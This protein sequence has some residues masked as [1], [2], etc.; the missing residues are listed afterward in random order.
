MRRGADRATDALREA[1]VQ[2]AARAREIHAEATLM[3]LGELNPSPY[4]IAAMQ[5]E[6]VALDALRAVLGRLR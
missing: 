5:R 1:L 3:A 6:L 4:R 2:L